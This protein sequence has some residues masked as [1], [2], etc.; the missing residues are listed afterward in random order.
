MKNKKVIYILLP[1][2]ILIWG[3]I[4]YRIL[5]NI[6]P[7]ESVSS[8]KS[9]IPS[10]ET[11]RADT[12]SLIADYPDPFLSRTSAPA[13]EPQ[14]I[15]PLQPREPV[16][17]P[18][19]VKPVITWPSVKYSG[20]IRNIKNDRQ[21]GVLQINGKD[22]LVSQNQSIGGI[23]VLQVYKDSVLLLYSGEKKVFRK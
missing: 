2:V 22:H 4:L 18:E 3:T 23:E 6:A 11:A 5:K 9:Y 1:L 20:I 19:P 12:F 14:S 15:A 7:E 10:L 17:K 8:G 13:P 16:I 21:L